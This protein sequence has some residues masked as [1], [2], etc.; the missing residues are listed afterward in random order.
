MRHRCNTSCLITFGAILGDVVTD[1]D[2]PERQLKIGRDILH[3]CDSTKYV[4]AFH[5]TKQ[6]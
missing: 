3:V 4:S 6:K 2:A 5:H 1:P